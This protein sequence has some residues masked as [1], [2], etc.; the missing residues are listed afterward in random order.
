[1]K[2]ATYMKAS[3]NFAVTLEK[4]NKRD[5]AVHTLNKLKHNFGEEMRVHNNLAIIQ[6]RNGD[7]SQA[8]SNFIKALEKEPHS[9]YPN[10]N[11]GLLLAQD[12]KKEKL[13][14]SLQYF[15]KALSHAKEK[16]D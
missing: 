12:K 4:L 13:Q 6:K 14:Q 5:K 3:T 16:N 15:E 10:Y 2:S 8:E 1:M 9:F 7:S 11:L